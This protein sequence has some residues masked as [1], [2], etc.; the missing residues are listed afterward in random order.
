MDDCI[1]SLLAD[2]YQLTPSI[3]A[4]RMSNSPSTLLVALNIRQRT[5]SRSES[6]LKTRL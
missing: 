1:Y 5:R 2:E 4:F 6:P 3:F